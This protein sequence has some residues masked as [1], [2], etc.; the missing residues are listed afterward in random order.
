[1]AIDI[2]DLDPF[3]PSSSPKIFTSASTLLHHSPDARGARPPPPA[4]A[5]LP[6]IPTS[7]DPLSN[8][9]SLVNLDPPPRSH[10]SPDPNRTKAHQARQEAVLLDLRRTPFSTAPLVDEPLSFA[11]SSFS[12]QPL[13]MGMAT[14]SRR[15]SHL[16][17]HDSTA[18]FSPPRRLSGLMMDKTPSSSPPL[19][20]TSSIPALSSP[21]LD[22][23]HP[24]S[25]PAHAAEAAFRRA[26]HNPHPPRLS[27]PFPLASSSH[28]EED[29]WSDFQSGSV[30]H[31]VDPLKLAWA[32]A[33]APRSKPKAAFVSVRDRE[34]DNKGKGKGWGNEG[35]QQQQPWKKEWTYD[36]N[37]ADAVQPIKLVGVRDGVHRALD[38][39]V[40]EG[41]RPNLPPRLRISTTWTL[42]YSLD[43]HGVSIQTMY[44]RMREGLD[45]T[46]SGVVIVVT[47]ANGSVFGAYV[48]EGLRESRSYYGDGSCFLWKSTPFSPSDFRVGSSIKSFK[49]TGK[50]QYLVLSE[51]DYLSV[52][53]GDGKFGLW[54]DSKF[55]KG[56]SATCPAFDN[57]PLPRGGWEKSSGGGKGDEAKFDVVR[58]ECWAV[59]L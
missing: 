9:S 28:V 1:M 19:I 8:F 18:A 43:Q 10:P 58:F 2:S 24:R 55:E 38:E 23:F 46:D 7:D 15:S 42:L 47:D 54:I 50:N 57:E 53:G 30:P 3:A 29:I 49:W 45:R 32:A 59:A 44:E 13:P 20:R 35:E 17:H 25:P 40:A 21:P 22:P 16:K 37:G 52:G 26:A 12:S 33:A 41:I 11:S 56:F 4:P 34:H 27:P 31:A 48:N 6:T 51:S 36:S 39:D 14:A 5:P